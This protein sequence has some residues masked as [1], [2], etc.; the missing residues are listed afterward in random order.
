[1]LTKFNFGLKFAY[2][3]LWENFEDSSKFWTV[4]WET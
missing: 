4:F 1:M 3:N 2:K